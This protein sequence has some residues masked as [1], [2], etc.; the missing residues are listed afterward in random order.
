[1][2][3][4]TPNTTSIQIVDLPTHSKPK[5]VLHD[6]LQSYSSGDKV[7]LTGDCNVNIYTKNTLPVDI[8]GRMDK[9]LSQILQNV[10]GLTDHI[11]EIQE[12]NN[13]YEQLD[14]SHNGRYIIDA[15]VL[16]IHNYYTVDIIVDVVILHD[17]ILVNSV[18]MNTAS[19]TNIINRYDTVFNNQGI[20]LNTDMFSENIRSLLDDTYKSSH[21]V[22][23]IDTNNN[24]THYSLDNVLSLASMGNQSSMGNQYYPSNLSPGTI[25][26]LQ[27]KGMAGLAENYFPPGL[28]TIS[29][30]LYCDKPP[31]VSGARPIDGCVF[32]QNSTSTE[33]TQPYMAPGLFYDRSSFPLP[34]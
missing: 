1:M 13:V 33:Y 29:S 19:N 11:Y 14:S 23:A 6:V 32:N 25:H 18:N 27:E 24:D 26:S 5:H 21:Q 34:T 3:Y 30:P 9:L 10:Y 15:T 28:T 20:L 4:M 7:T 17:E 8:K 22:I 31:T 12:L 16:S 2:R